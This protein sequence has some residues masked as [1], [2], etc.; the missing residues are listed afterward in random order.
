MWFAGARIFDAL[1][2]SSSVV[3]KLGDTELSV[4]PLDVT[5]ERQQLELDRFGQMVGRSQRMRELFADL[6]RSVT[7]SSWRER[8]RAWVYRL[9]FHTQD[10]IAVNR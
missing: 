1:I 10:G 6:Q 5:V 9:S 7:R 4:V 2:A 3:L 8:C